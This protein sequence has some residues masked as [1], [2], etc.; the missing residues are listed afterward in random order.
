[1]ERPSLATRSAQIAF[2]AVVAGAWF[3][4]TETA[5]ISALFLP[6]VW[7]S[8]PDP[9]AFV[10]QLK[11]KAGLAAEHWSPTM[12]ARRFRAEKFGA[13]LR[14]AEAGALAAHGLRLAQAAQ[15]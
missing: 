13:P 14:R 7:S 15:Q 11:R 12:T 4:A 10:R 8:L 9:R 1:M 5:S 3:L 6:S 2:L